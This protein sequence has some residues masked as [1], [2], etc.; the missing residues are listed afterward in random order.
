[1]ICGCRL[2]AT[3]YCRKRL[4]VAILVLCGF[5][6]NLARVP[7]LSAIKNYKY[8]DFYFNLLFIPIAKTK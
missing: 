8:I 6:F 5:G 2:S 4:T 3:G 7:L 1:M